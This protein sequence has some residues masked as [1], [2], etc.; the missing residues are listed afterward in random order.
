[1]NEMI[2]PQ[3]D[4]RDLITVDLG[5]VFTQDDADYEQRDRWEECMTMEDIIEG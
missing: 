5:E 2:D 1:M 3:D 4:L